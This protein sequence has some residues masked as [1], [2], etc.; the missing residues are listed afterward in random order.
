[1]NVAD[2]DQSASL[3]TAL[4]NKSDIMGYISCS[5]VL[6]QFKFNDS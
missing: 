5:C 6:G 3:N 1:M 4:K 2:E